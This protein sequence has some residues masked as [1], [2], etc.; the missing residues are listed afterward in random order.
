M[1]VNLANLTL[2]LKCCNVLTFELL[3]AM[4]ANSACANTG[5]YDHTVKLW[6]VRAKQACHIHGIACLTNAK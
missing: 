4:L 1:H 2:G 3:H 6:D 5:G